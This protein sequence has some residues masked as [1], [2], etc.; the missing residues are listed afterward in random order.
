MTR[1]DKH[2]PTEVSSKAPV[3]VVRCPPSLAN[4]PRPKH[5]DPRFDRSMGSFNPDLF[6][7]SYTF[8]DDLQHRELDMVRERLRKD[9]NMPEH[10]RQD[11]ERLLDRAKTKQKQLERDSRRHALIKEWRQQES[12]L[13]KAGKKR[14][15][16]LKSSDVRKMEL[17]D[18]FKRMKQA[19][20]NL[21]VDKVLEKKRK[22]KA[23][24]QHRM[25]PNRH[26][27]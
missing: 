20:P 6:R 12:E 4:Q 10:K 26:S 21:D 1:T 3:S 16:Y 2:A 9:K 13:V 14:P 25:L 23:S 17:V 8:V 19:N 24:K 18:Q 7:K 15:Y 5:H 27:E 11:L 22:R